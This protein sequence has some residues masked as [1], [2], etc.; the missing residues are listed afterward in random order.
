[1]NNDQLIESL[2][3]MTAPELVRL[4]K[5]LEKKWGVSALPI[6]NTQPLNPAQETKVETAQT[7]F[8]V[9]LTGFAADKKIAVIKVL[10]EVA[11]LGLVEAK[12]ATES[13]PKVLK[14]SVSREEAD[15]IVQKLTEAGGK[16]EVK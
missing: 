11:S 16:V 14:E 8:S 9:I 7:E 6:V 10:R 3:N 13:L 2:N 5:E 4:T 15:M 1:M 12:A